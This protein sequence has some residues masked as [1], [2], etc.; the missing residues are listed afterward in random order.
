MRNG[1]G[2][3]RADFTHLARGGAVSRTNSLRFRHQCDGSLTILR[4]H[5]EDV[6]P[7]NLDFLSIAF[8]IRNHAHRGPYDQKNYWICLLV[9]G[10]SLCYC[11][12]YRIPGS[13][14]FGSTNYCNCNRICSITRQKAMNTTSPGGVKQHHARRIK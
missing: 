13:H 6:F 3:K 1:T 10:R 5:V 2:Q 4:P 7:E 11:C 8:T 12:I 9:A 14:F